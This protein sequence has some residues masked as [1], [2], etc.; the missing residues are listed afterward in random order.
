MLKIPFDASRS[1][2]QNFRV[3]I[4]ERMVISLRLVWHRAF[5]R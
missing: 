2:D 3:L 4:P 5:V 1:A